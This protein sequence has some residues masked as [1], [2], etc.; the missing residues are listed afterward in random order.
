MDK[1][2][3]VRACVQGLDALLTLNGMVLCK[4]IAGLEIRIPVHEF[5]Q[6]G[7][8]R[9]QVLALGEQG[10]LSCNELTPVDCA[11]HVVV[12]LQKDRGPES[13]VQAHVLF[14]LAEQIKKGQRLKKA[15]MLDVSVNLPVSFLR[16]RFF[17][18]LQAGAEESDFIRIQD[19][20]LGLTGQIQARKTSAL[21]P[22]FSVRNQE[23][24]S[25]YGL[26][27]QEVHKVFSSRVN[28]LCSTFSLSDSV[29]DSGAWLFHR[30]RHSSVYA[31]LNAQHLPLLQFESGENMTRHQW[32]MHVGVLGGEVFVL[33]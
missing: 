26:D 10:L 18:V 13:L 22:Y 29:L 28:L 30:V 15:R 27:L 16:W 12:E 24:A 1:T 31:L 7:D 21:L 17:D 14:S 2:L 33:R 8:N 11:V 6:S 23:V 20:V 32:P 25:A 9:V 19:F 3:L 5:I 4:L